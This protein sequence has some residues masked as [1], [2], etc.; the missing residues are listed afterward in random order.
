M[1]LDQEVFGAISA[2]DEAPWIVG[3]DWNRNPKIIAESGAVESVG[4][5]IAVGTDQVETCIPTCEEHRILD[6]FILGPGFR[7]AGRKIEVDLEAS[8]ATHRPVKVTLEGDP[9]VQ[10]VIGLKAPKPYEFTPEQLKT[11]NY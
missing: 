3:G 7:E 11:R 6:L 9:R 1:E 4:G 5:F 2:L 10:E 8:I